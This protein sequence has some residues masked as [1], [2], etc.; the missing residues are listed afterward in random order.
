MEKKG[1]KGI[2][3]ERTKIKINIIDQVMKMKGNTSK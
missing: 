2:K 3:E 1:I